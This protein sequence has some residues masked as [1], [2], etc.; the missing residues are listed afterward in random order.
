MDKY[1]IC[2]FYEERFKNCK[3]GVHPDF[4]FFILQAG[5][6]CNVLFDDEDRYY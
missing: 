6:A 3:L 5:V 2:I 4:A 1:G